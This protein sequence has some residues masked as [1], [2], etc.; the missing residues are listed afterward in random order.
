[1]RDLRAS[2]PARPFDS[3]SSTLPAPL[4]TPGTKRGIAAIGYKQYQATGAHWN[5]TQAQTALNHG[6]PHVWYDYS[7]PSSG[8]TLPVAPNG[9]LYMPMFWDLAGQQYSG[10]PAFNSANIG[11]A[12]Q[13][14]GNGGYIAFLNEAYNGTPGVTAGAV[15]PTVAAANWDTLA[16]D[17]RVIAA[18]IKLIG[19]VWTNSAGAITW[20]NTFW[21][22]ITSRKPDIVAIHEYAS[23][24][25][26]TT[27]AVTTITSALA[28][29]EAAYP[30][31]PYALTEFAMESTA[32]DQQM[33]DLFASLLPLLEQRYWLAFYTTFWGG[34]ANITGLSGLTNHLYNDDATPTN[35][36]N[37]YAAFP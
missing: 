33:E 6:R 31:Q 5:L 37:Q 23:Q 29:F 20:Y 32:T 25:Q 36:G 3:T 12:V 10:A 22:S 11:L 26:T 2:R 21:K 18:G 30:R 16:T 13:Y 24:A 27:Q 35:I 7:I 9:G 19:P 15:D 4:F 1:M 28:V 17:S 14:A 8:D 34:P